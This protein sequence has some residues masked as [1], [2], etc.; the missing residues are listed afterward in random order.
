MNP[1]IEKIAD[2]LTRRGQINLAAVAV[3]MIVSV[4]GIFRLSIITDFSVFM[5]SQSRFT[6]AAEDMNSAFGDSS[7][8]VLLVEVPDNIQS[9]RSLP[10]LVSSFK[11]IDG[12]VSVDGP[13]PESMSTLSDKA[14]EARVESLQ[15]VSGGT[16]LIENK[17]THW[18]TIRF[19]L[20]EEA[21][22][23]GIIREIRRIA[24][25]ENLNYILSGE[26]Y[27]EAEVFSYILKIL[28]IL[29]PAAIVLMLGV[30]RLRIGS[31][32]ATMLSMVPAVIGAVLTLGAVSWIFGAVS[33]LSV[34]IPIFVIVLGSADGL[35]VTSHVMD[36]LSAG[37]SNHR[38]VRETM[39]AVGVPIIMTTLTTMA[40][41]LSM[42]VIDSPAIRQ[43]GVI[44]AGGILVAGLATW[45]VLPV[46]LL[47]L[48]PLESSKKP[49]EGGII[50]A[51]AALRGWPAIVITLVIIGA[52]LPGT[53]KLHA[54]FSMVDMY[55]PRTAV[56]QNIESA[57]DI[58]GGSIP[59]FAI[60]EAK[61][62]YDPVLADAIIDLQTKAD[63]TGIAGNSVSLYTIISRAA[64]V[65]SG[66]VAYP[67]SSSVAKMLARGIEAMN[68]AFSETY[69]SPSGLCRAVF[70]LSDLE[71]DT[72]DS[73]I[74]LT[75]DAAGSSGIDI[76]PVGTAFAMKSMNDKIIGQQL[77]SLLLAAGIVFL[78]SALTQRSLWLGL[79]A[80][81][82]IVVTLVGLF[83]TMGYVGIELSVLTGIMF[84]LTVGVG[85]DYAIHYVS[86]YRYCRKRG[87]TDPAKSALEY[88]ATPVLANAIGLS[89]GFTAMMFSPLRVHVILSTLMWVTMVLSAGITLTLLPTLLGK[90]TRTAAGK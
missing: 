85:I 86:L 65:I 30:F 13:I 47:R 69:I 62:P 76:R 58:L 11:E 82:P 27:L 9:L 17:D 24:E 39:S 64:A 28:L 54:S 14:F 72:L 48:K 2:A 19:M 59:V 83:G 57:T 81:A 44:A 7:Q 78:L 41:F 34:L 23:R 31:F 29:P 79:A 36:R 42:L 73:F 63:A 80:V 10:S 6:A 75:Q 49:G 18:A 89:I 74:T 20:S 38:A 66:E 71:D 5:P 61:D 68:P 12:V 50:K 35:H 84:G 37:S 52:F 46:L 33:I 53:L 70:F 56:R 15:K 43:M 88:V 25:S 51:T 21:Q 32:R 45:F 90:K 87:D 3:C 60:F 4:V 8:Q 26:P 22:P 40:G 16:L 67:S 77:Q 55:K 1:R